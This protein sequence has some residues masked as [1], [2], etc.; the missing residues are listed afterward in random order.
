[1]A[2]RD[3][4]KHQQDLKAERVLKACWSAS[5]DI[6]VV[7]GIWLACPLFARGGTV[8]SARS[9][10]ELHRML[11]QARAIGA[12]ARPPTRAHASDTTREPARL[13]VIVVLAAA[14]T[15]GV[16]LALIA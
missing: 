8:L 11:R 14:F 10:G 3:E 12:H 1:M 2:S 6:G 7:D 16:I 5:Y 13:F 15:I 4:W 9:P